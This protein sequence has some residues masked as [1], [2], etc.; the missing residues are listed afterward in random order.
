VSTKDGRIVSW[1]RPPLGFVSCSLQY[2]CYY[3][4]AHVTMSIRR[5]SPS[6]SR[7]TRPRRRF[8]IISPAAACRRASARARPKDGA[9]TP[10][11]IATMVRTS[12][13]S[14]RVNPAGRGYAG[15]LE[16][17]PI[18][19]RPHGGDKQQTAGRNG[20]SAGGQSL[21]RCQRLGPGQGLT[22]VEL[23]R[24]A[25]PTVTYQVLELAASTTGMPMALEKAA[26]VGTAMLLTTTGS[27]RK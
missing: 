20:I 5:S 27:P 7:G 8:W 12:A 26:Y 18:P 24:P 1:S 25:G 15:C 9:P 21:S 19:S 22:A 13:S 14:I 2:Y 6:R 17:S 23:A 11:M 4:R 3:S 16:P 10:T